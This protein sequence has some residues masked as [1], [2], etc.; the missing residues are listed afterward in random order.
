MRAQQ[1]YCRSTRTQAKVAPRCGLTERGQQVSELLRGPRS[2][3]SR[4]GA[5]VMAGW[6]SDHRRAA[7]RTLTPPVLARPR[8]WEIRERNGARWNGTAVTPSQTAGSRS[9]PMTPAQPRG[10]VMCGNRQPV[11]TSLTDCLLLVSLPQRG[12]VP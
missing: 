2:V 8:K 4:R 1:A 9:L 12:R 5:F 11:P 6:G 10:T 7:V 3:M